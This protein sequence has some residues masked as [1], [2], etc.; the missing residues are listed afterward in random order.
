MVGSWFSDIALRFE[1]RSLSIW[2][3]ASLRI[4][5]SSVIIIVLVASKRLDWHQDAKGA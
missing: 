3:V 1:L 4:P 5:V 2:S